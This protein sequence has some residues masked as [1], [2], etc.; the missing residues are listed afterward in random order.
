MG[1]SNWSRE[2]GGAQCLPGGKTAGY[3]LGGGSH[4]V[5]EMVA[6]G[7]IMTTDTAQG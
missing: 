4:A 1:S 3:R 2:S 7:K 6:S 5:G